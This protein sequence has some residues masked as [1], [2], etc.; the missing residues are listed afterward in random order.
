MKIALYIFLIFLV[1]CIFEYTSLDFFIQDYFYNYKSNTWL[2]NK[3]TDLIYKYIFYDFAR[4]FIGISAL[5][6][7]LV[8]IS[9]FFKTTFIKYRIK[10]IIVFLSL[11]LTPLFVSYLKKETKI[12][13]PRELLVYQGSVEYKRL[14][15]KKD[16]K[17]T[18]R[19]FPAGHASGGF[20]L[21]ILSILARNKKESKQIFYSVL[22]FA[23]SMAIYKLAIGDHFLSHTFVSF[24]I[25]L[26]FKEVLLN[27]F[28][29]KYENFNS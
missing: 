10:S 13:C 15:D 8:F 14:F 19:C 11:S 23:S 20:A 4:I 28:R 7:L 24:F 22:V 12:S 21:L 27:I 3:N 29:E 2:I 5:L 6:S 25:A 18:G 16:I 26:I 9:T 1:I 17:S